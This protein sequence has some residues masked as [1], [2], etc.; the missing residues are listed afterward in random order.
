MAPCMIIMTRWHV[1]DLIG[2]LLQDSGRNLRVLR[3]PALAEQEEDHWIREWQ[4]TDS[5]WRPAWRLV[6]RAKDAPL[7]AELKP[8]DFLLE[9]RQRL[10]QASW[11]S[12][13]QQNPIVVGG[14]QLPI[15]KLKA[16]ALW[17]RE[18]VV[19]SVRYWDKADS[20]ADDAAYTA[21]VLLHKMKDNTFVISDIERGRWRALERERR[22]RN[23][24]ELD[25]Q[26]YKNYKIVVE[27]E[28]GS[29][30][31]ESAETTLRNLAGFRVYADRVTGSKQV[32]AE[33][34]AAQVQSGNVFFVAA[35]WVREFLDECETWPNG[36]YKDQV[37][38]AAGAFNW[39]TRSSYDT[40]YV[41]PW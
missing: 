22:I 25:A 24:A 7:F 14:G 40:T 17:N 30:G 11:Q 23:C 9:Q 16:V 5:G 18:N 1:N 3:Y 27:Q 19:A 29:G 6:R 8:K 39:L 10:T 20:N 31:K 38:A 36:K 41:A 4:A 13:Y 35:R 12:L 34:F 28:P 15:E 26:Y 33:P 37:D 2:R 32:R 21:G